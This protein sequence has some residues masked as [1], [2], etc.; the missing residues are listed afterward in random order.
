MTFGKPKPLVIIGICALIIILAWSLSC[1]KKEVFFNDFD[2]AREESRDSI[3]ASQIY[4]IKEGD[5][6]SSFDVSV[7]FDD[8]DL[9]HD[10]FHTNLDVVKVGMDAE[11]DNLSMRERCRLCNQIMEEVK[12]RLN[13]Y[14]NKT[15]YHEL[16]E[17]NKAYDY[18]IM[19]RDKSLH[20]YHDY[21]FYFYDTNYTYSFP[22]YGNMTV[23]LTGTKAKDFYEFSY[24][25]GKLKEFDS[26]YGSKNNVKNS[27]TTKSSSE[28]SSKKSYDPYDVHK[29]KSAQVF[30][31]DKYEEFYD[32]E[33]DYED[34]DE[35]YDAA[36]DYWNEYN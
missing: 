25:D 7:T 5:H 34:E 15:R 22:S 14:Y 33:D 8:N 17:A 3:D 32:Y 26:K 11:F 6:V 2:A 4:D 28:S 24:S 13:D 27:D 9:S 18:T 16:F 30:A 29:Y 12:P 35:A 21:K 19:Y 20:V 1:F 31:D 23:T 10:W 36:E